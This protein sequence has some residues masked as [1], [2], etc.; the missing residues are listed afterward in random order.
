MGEEIRAPSP[1]WVEEA[2][3]EARAPEGAPDLRKRPMAAS[4]M[5]GRSTLGEETQAGS[6]DEVEEI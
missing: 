5:V 2:P 1:A 3:V 4:A 6:D